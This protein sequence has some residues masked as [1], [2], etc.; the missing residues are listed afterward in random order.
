MKHRSSHPFITAPWFLPVSVL[1]I[2]LITY[3]PTC[4]YPFQFD[5]LGNI[6]KNFNIRTFSAW[7]TMLHYRRWVGEWINS[8]IYAFDGFSP[9][10]YRLCNI[11]IHLMAGALVYA[12]IAWICKRTKTASL[13]Y[14]KQHIIAGL[15]SALF[16][17]HPVQ[18]QTVSYAIQGKLEGLASMLTLAALAL[19]TQVLTHTQTLHRIGFFTLGLLA[20]VIACGTKEIAFM[21]PALLVL[22]DW[23][24][25]AQQSWKSFK[26]RIGWH[27]A[28]GSIIGALMVHY[29]NPSF[30]LTAFKLQVVLE[31]NRGNVL[32]ESAE[33]LITPLVFLMSQFKVLVHYLGMFLWPFNISVDYDWK[34]STSA[35]SFDVIAPFLVLAAL[36]GAAL[37]HRVRR[38]FPIVPFGILW[39][40]VCMAPR[41][42]II[43]SQE[44][45]VDYKT[46]LASVGWLFVLSVG[47]IAL[48]QYLSTQYLKKQSISFAYYSF[49]YLGCLGLAGSTY[50]RNQVWSSAAA[51]WSDIVEKAPHKARGFNNLG[52]ELVRQGTQQKQ[53]GNFEGAEALYAEAI[54]HYHR[55]IELDNTYPDPYSNLSVCHTIQGDIDDAIKVAYKAIQLFPYYPE[56]Y[57]NLGTQLLEKKDFEHAEM[58]FQNAIKCRDHYGKAYYNLARCYEQQGKNEE[59]WQTLKQAS[60][61]D[62]DTVPQCWLALGQL[63]LK[64][65]K[66]DDAIAALEKYRQVDVEATADR[67]SMGTMYL[68]NA[69]HLDSRVDKAAPLYLELTKMHPNDNRY[70]HNLAECFFASAQYENAQKCYARA[71]ACSSCEFQTFLRLA[72]SYEKTGQYDDAANVMS[73]IIHA[74]N[75]DQLPEEVMTTCRKELMRIN[76]AAIVARTETA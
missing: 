76:T 30:F 1:F 74:D 21:A 12:L 73:S 13:T 34:L 65:N 54:T 71:T 46:Y 61:A 44:L 56:A 15:T 63:S 41:T 75:K 19:M 11:A 31:N 72:Q 58:A 24:F 53:E 36:V 50:Q 22:I 70:W 8:V 6:T 7:G 9:F 52:V 35:L 43:P 29:M 47:L 64:L 57:M 66:R 67:W 3:L 48:V 5:D 60:T 16:L 55:A 10:Y 28:Y 37:S 33:T 68:A 4:T 25:V 59:A 39:F 14:Q 51:F 23:F 38:S 62:F 27:L 49:L 32:T 45:A 18:S 40:F 69:Y 20:S 17:L 26:S 2:T 42:T